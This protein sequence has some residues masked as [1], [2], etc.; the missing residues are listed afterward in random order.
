MWDFSDGRADETTGDMILENNLYWN[1]GNS[2]PTN[3]SWNIWDPDAPGND[4]PNG[5]FANPLLGNPIGMTIPRW[6]P[7]TKQFL[8]GQTTIRGEFTRMVNLYGLPQAGSPAINAS[9]AAFMP[10]DDIFGRSRGVSPDIGAVE[11]VTTVDLTVISGSG[12]GTYS[13][14]QVVA[15]SAAAAPT[16]FVFSQWVGDTID[17]T[18]PYAASTT[19]MANADATITATYEVP[20]YILGVVSGSGD[21]AYP[22]G[23]VVDI[24]VTMPAGSTFHEWTGDIN[25]LADRYDPNTTIIM[26]AAYTSVT[27][28]YTPPPPVTYALTVANGSGSGDYTDGQQVQISA[29]L[30]P[31]GDL[32][33]DVW[34]GDTFYVVFLDEPESLVVMPDYDIAVTAT[35]TVTVSRLTVLSGSGSGIYSV[36]AAVAIS[37]DPAPTGDVFDQW[38]GDT[39]GVADIFDAN[40]TITMAASD[41]TVTATYLADLAGDL[42]EDGGVNLIDLNMVLIDWGKSGPAISDPRSDA[43]GNGTVDLIDLNIVL[44]DWGK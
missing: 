20:T 23:E 38:T 27:A 13:P 22:A 7:G 6:L 42:N 37:A 28:L 2:I 29:D 41:A 11:R 21:G 1:N 9:N 43:D 16:G 24:R 35:Y 19:M 4:D 40:T 44:I 32:P 8:S 18:N 25:N 3:D 10:L 33:F 36:G 14:S 34:V 5:V 39:G 31:G 30:G 15:I 12:G 17:V 26:P